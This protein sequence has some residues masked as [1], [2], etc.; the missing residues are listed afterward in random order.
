M[1]V[2]PKLPF[3][4]QKFSNRVQAVKRRRGQVVRQGSAK[5]SSGVRIPSTPLL[6][7]LVSSTPLGVFCFTFRRFRNASDGQTLMTPYCVIYF[8]YGMIRIG[9]FYKLQF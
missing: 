2:E 7:R 3:F 8:V 4:S 6:A 5:P 9:S 1:E